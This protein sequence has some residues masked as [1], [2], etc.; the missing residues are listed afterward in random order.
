MTGIEN[1][2]GSPPNQLTFE[3]CQRAFENEGSVVQTEGQRAA[4]RCARLDLV[5]LRRM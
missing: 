2:A 4:A 3:E 5:V 1:R